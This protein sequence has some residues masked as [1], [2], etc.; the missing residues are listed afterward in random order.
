MDNNWIFISGWTWVNGH[1]MFIPKWCLFSLNQHF[2]QNMQF[3]TIY[4]GMKIK[5]E[6][7][8][9]LTFETRWTQKTARLY[10]TKKGQASEQSKNRPNRFFNFKCRDINICWMFI[11]HEQSGKNKITPLQLCLLMRRQPWGTADFT[12]RQQ[13]RGGTGEAAGHTAFHL[14]FSSEL[15]VISILIIV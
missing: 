6:T 10:P 8:K 15:D 14:H 11:M 1:H 3:R 13:S 2:G 5:K 12:L 9:F 7:Q 4:N